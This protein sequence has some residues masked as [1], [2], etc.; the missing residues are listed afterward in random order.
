M[1]LWSKKA[2][3]TVIEQQL[4]SFLYKERSTVNL[5]GKDMLPMAGGI[6]RTGH[7][8]WVDRIFKDRRA[9]NLARQGACPERRSPQIP[10]LSKTVPIRPPGF[11]TGCPERPIFAAMKLIEQELGKHQI[12]GD[13]GCHLFAALPPFEVGGA[14]MGYGL[15]PPS[16]AA[17]DRGGK[18][19]AIS[20]LGDGGFWQNGLGSSIGNMVFNKSD[21]VAV[22]VDNQYSAATGGRIFC[23][24]A[25]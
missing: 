21:T 5:H 20:I 15:G 10:D 17:F 12:S 24:A 22:I 25:Q 14:T 4:G 13:I 11:C 16:N 1:C 3:Q 8:G 19:R 9:G 7:A 6:H 18:R 2:S 23:R